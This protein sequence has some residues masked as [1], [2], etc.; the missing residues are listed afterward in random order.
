MVAYNIVNHRFLENALAEAKQAGVEVIAMKVARPFY[1]GSNQAS[2]APQAKP[3]LEAEIPGEWSIP[4]NAYLWALQNPDLSAAVSNMV[5]ADQVVANL[6]LPMAGSG[7]G[8]K[9]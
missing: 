4:E 9:E 5:N 7:L 6:K 3:A 1:A 2:A 8:V